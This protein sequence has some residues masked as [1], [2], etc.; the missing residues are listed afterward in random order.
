MNSR[1]M[2]KRFKTFS[3]LLFLILTLCSTSSFA[4]GVLIFSS[5][6]T[7]E[8]ATKD[9]QRISEI[10]NQQ[11]TTMEAT[12][13]ERNVFRVVVA[14]SSEEDRTAL[15]KTAADNNLKPWYLSTEKL[16]QAAQSSD[17]TESNEVSAG[18]AGATESSNLNLDDVV[19]SVGGTDPNAVL[20]YLDQATINSTIL[21]LDAVRNRAQE[22]IPD[23][24]PR[25]E[26]QP[27]IE[28]I[29]E[30]PQVEEAEDVEPPA[31]TSA[32]E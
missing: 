14:V 11:A 28:Q 27:P 23:F 17:V 13:N 24:E 7:S 12:V 30:M 9:A 26:E 22:L 5:W 32:T 15:T 6:D 21:K 3:P 19:L 4:S 2:S 20:Q 10:L 8:K 31:E 29:P 18:A 25:D 1:G 16:A